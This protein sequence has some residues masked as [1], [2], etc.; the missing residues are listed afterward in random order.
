MTRKKPPKSLFR[1]DMPAL[2]AVAAMATLGCAVG[3]DSTDSTG[4]P[5][6]KRSS[7][8]KQSVSKQA[9]KWESRPSTESN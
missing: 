3:C 2:L 4:K 9:P 8:S 5:V 7:V 6:S 1:S